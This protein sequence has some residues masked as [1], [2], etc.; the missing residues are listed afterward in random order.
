MEQAAQVAKVHFVLKRKGTHVAKIAQK[1]W[2]QALTQCL[3]GPATGHAREQ[4]RSGKACACGSRG[5]AA[6]AVCLCM[7][8]AG[9]DVCVEEKLEI[10]RGVCASHS[11][12]SSK[13]SSGIP[14]HLA[15]DRKLQAR[16][17]FG[18]SA[19]VTTLNLSSCKPKPA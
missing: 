16:E 19:G 1:L 13:S 14:V 4:S 18:R 8:V 5:C 9:G 6:A 11:C 15:L 2:G 3:R 17:W 10:I 12:M 7:G